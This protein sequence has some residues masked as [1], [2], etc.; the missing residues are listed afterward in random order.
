MDEDHFSV[1]VKSGKG[2]VL[3]AVSELFDFLVAVVAHVVF[4]KFE[5]RGLVHASSVIR[6]VD[7]ERLVDLSGVFQ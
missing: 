3:L 6:F 1:E 5:V 7:L 2:F 4:T